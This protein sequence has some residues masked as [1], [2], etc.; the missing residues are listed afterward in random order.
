MSLD[1][2][3]YGRNHC[4]LC[5]KLYEAVQPLALELGL[6]VHVFDVD[7]EVALAAHFGRL[8]PLLVPGKP[9]TM[10]S[11]LCQTR[12]DA[13][14]QAALRA[15]AVGNAHVSNLLSSGL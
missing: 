1:I 4:S 9:G 12:L 8:I 7:R 2:T 15:W 5:D 14:A 11:P 6:T 13:P 3:L 10:A